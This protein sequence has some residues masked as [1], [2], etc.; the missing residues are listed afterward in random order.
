MTSTKPTF[1]SIETLL[2]HKAPMLL[3][4]RVVW[5]NNDAI[6]CEVII[7]PSCVFYDEKINGIASHV[8]IEYM[9]QTIG[10]LA[11]LKAH[12][13]NQPPPIG[14]LLGGRAYKDSGQVFTVGQTLQVSATLAMSD[15]T[16]GVYQA[17][18]EVNGEQIA[19]SQINAYVPSAAVLAQLT[20]AK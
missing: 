2:P 17:K 9:A 14:F 8:G 3:I 10:A 15:E 11:G 18:I 13:N 6:G 7:K 19:S 1:P 5:A 16:M 4:D 12:N 20:A